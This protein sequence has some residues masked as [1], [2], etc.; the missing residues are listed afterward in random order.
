MFGTNSHKVDKMI[1]LAGLKI[2]IQ[3]KP[4]EYRI[5]RR[6]LIQ[7][8]VLKVISLDMKVHECACTH[9]KSVLCKHTQA[10]VHM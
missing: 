10:A 1:S 3:N 9:I 7:M 8:I 4:V 2:S 5:L 6:H